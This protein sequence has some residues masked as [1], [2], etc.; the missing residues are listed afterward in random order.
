MPNF[1]SS[2]PTPTPTESV[3]GAG[4]SEAVLGRRRQ[5][6]L[7]RVGGGGHQRAAASSDPGLV[8]C[9]CRATSADQALSDGLV[10]LLADAEAEDSGVARPSAA[11]RFQ[12]CPGEARGREASAVAEQ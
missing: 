2:C 8:D 6:A 10:G 1:S 11:E 7:R 12:V 5:I 9:R 3:T 4:I